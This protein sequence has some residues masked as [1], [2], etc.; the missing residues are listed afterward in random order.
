MFEKTGESV[1][2]E[3][4]SE[5]GSA[6]D[7]L[8]GEDDAFEEPAPSTF[9]SSPDLDSLLN[10][11]LRSKSDLPDF[12]ADIASALESE[13]LDESPVF[14]KTGESVSNESASEVGSALDD[15]FGEDDAF[16]EPAPSTF[17]SSPD[18][19][20]L[21]NEQLRSKSDLPDFSADIASALESEPVDEAEHLDV[22][23]LPELT[24]N[25]PDLDSL[26]EEQLGG[27]VENINVDLSS[28]LEVSLS[29]TESNLSIPP[30][31]DQSSEKE[32]EFPAEVKGVLDGLFADDDFEEP[33][34]ASVSIPESFEKSHPDVHS[35]LDELFADDEDSLD[36]LLDDSSEISLRNQLSQDPEQPLRS[37]GSEGLPKVTPT[38]A[39]I[40]LQQ[41][42]RDKAIETYQ[43]LVAKKPN[44]LALKARLAEIQ[45]L[46]K[47]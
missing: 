15:L 14:E 32:T 3:S 22:S 46:P 34:P 45:N 4:A 17:A 27:E 21:L 11:Q 9:A 26:L 39:E 5:V 12:S 1:S 24:G 18:L 23:T 13:P 29:E 38:L 35:A 31:L 25:T 43:E 44:D 7:D 8:F 2:N 42:L 6:L 28:E 36:G 20:S 40:Y 37:S 41:G 47:N 33:A 16:E 19:D 10:E 30:S